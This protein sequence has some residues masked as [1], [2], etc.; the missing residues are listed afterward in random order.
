MAAQ[1]PTGSVTI[2]AHSTI[3]KVPNI[4]G[5]IP[6]PRIPSLGIDDKNSQLIAEA[7]F[8]II[9]KIIRITG[10]IAKIAA[11]QSIVYENF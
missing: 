5:K 6:P 4:A 7:P 10:A 2:I 11:R 8:F 9:T 3:E 1:T